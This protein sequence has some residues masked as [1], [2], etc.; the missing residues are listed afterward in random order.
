ML[1][2]GLWLEHD[3]DKFPQEF[4][5]IFRI[6]GGAVILNEACANIFKQFNLGES[7]LTPLKIH[8]PLSQELWRDETYYFLNLCEKRKFVRK[9]QHH[10]RLKYKEYPSGKW[11]Y[12]DKSAGL[13]VDYVEIDKSVIDC[14]IDLWH[15]PHLVYGSYFMSDGLYTTLLEAGLAEAWAAGACKLI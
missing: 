15:D 1:P 5:Y 7:T 14:D 8:Q 10:E 4:E 11:K 12:V 9:Q 2:D 13:N 6:R 3:M